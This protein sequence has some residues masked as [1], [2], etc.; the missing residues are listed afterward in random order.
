M[1]IKIDSLL[2]RG[3][4]AP[5]STTNAKKDLR[6]ARSCQDFESVFLTTLWRSMAK[7][8]GMDVGGWDVLLSQA[9]GKA[10]AGSGG[11]G[12]AKVLYERLSKS[13]SNE[14]PGDDASERTVPEPEPW[15]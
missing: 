11:I 10:W 4:G 1:D 6:L 3:Q 5:V 15:P 8:S 13:S 9:V 12:L 2:Y 7:N 14:L